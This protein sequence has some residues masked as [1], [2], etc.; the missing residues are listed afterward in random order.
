[1][2]TD[3]GGVVG[4]NGRKAQC[5]GFTRVG[6]AD[7]TG[8]DNRDTRNGCNQLGSAAWHAMTMGSRDSRKLDSLAF[9]NFCMPSVLS[10]PSERSIG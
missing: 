7:R 9:A 4:G 10:T 1:M 6:V 5:G 8:L 3:A 2:R